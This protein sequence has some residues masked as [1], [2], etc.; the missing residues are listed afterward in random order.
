MEEGKK[1]EFMDGEGQM[2]RKMFTAYEFLFVAVCTDDAWPDGEERTY[3]MWD[4]IE[5]PGLFPELEDGGWRKVRTLNLWMEKGRC[6]GKCSLYMI[7]YLWLFLQMM[8]GLMGRRGH[9]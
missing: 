8:P 2:F 4:C 5:V 7:F 9:T 1:T 6:L 3:L